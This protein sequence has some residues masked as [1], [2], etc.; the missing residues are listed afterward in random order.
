MRAA[1]CARFDTAKREGLEV[2]ARVSDAAIGGG[3]AQRRGFIPACLFYRPH[4]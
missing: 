4:S 1:I 2:V 3:T